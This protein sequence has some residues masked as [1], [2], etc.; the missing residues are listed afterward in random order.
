MNSITYV[1]LDVHKTT[2]AVAVAE[3]GAMAFKVGDVVRLKFGGA[4]MTVSKLFKSPE[5]REM[6]QCTWFDN[7]PREHRAAFVNDSLEATEEATLCIR[8]GE[9]A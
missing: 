2:I 6:V 9:H 3:G 7:K 1:G 8:Q 4:L 5:G